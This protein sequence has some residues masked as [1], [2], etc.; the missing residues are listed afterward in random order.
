MRGGGFNIT[1]LGAILLARNLGDFTRLQRK[2]LRVVEYRGTGRLETLREREETRG[3]AAGFAELMDY[4][5]ARLPTHEANGR[6]FQRA[7]PDFPPLA[8]RELVAN[9]LIH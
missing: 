2:A 8:V 3:Y 1:N 4:I 9:A 7:T 6:A 5:H